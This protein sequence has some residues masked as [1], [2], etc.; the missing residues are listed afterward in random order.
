MS[1]IHEH[2]DSTDSIDLSLDRETLGTL[3]VRHPWAVRFLAFEAILLSLAS[4]VPFLGASAFHYV[5]FG[6]L[7]SLAAVMAVGAT[8]IG[9]RMGVRKARKEI[10]YGDALNAVGV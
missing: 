5:V 9:V 7:L 10:R 3:L 2:G 4:V 8:A 6:I 1:Q